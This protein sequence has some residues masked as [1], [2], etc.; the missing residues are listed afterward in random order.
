MDYSKCMREL[1]FKDSNPFEIK[2]KLHQRNICLCGS[3]LGERK[4][5][6]KDFI[7]LFGSACVGCK[8]YLDFATFGGL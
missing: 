1:D 4:L 2:I 5:M 6:Y 3:L 7:S 8:K